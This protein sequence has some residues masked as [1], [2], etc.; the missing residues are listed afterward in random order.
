[1]P[2][3]PHREARAF[4]EEFVIAFREF[5][6]NLIA[7]RYAAPYMAMHM[8]GS[9]DLFVKHEEIGQYFQRVVDSYRQQ[10]CRLCRYKDLEVLPLGELCSLATVTWELLTE[11]STVLSTWRESYNLVRTADWLR[12]FASVDH[13]NKSPD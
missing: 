6:G 8:D 13:A 3:D 4:F 2:T 11:S 1:M 5:D 10:G 7:A 12:V 9:T